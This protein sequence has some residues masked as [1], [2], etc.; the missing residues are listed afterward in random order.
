[1]GDLVKELRNVADDLERVVGLADKPF[2]DD[3]DLL[4]RAAA[5][6]DTLR[7]A[8]REI[9]DEPKGTWHGESYDKC[10]P[11]KEYYKSVIEWC[12]DRA[13]EALNVNPEFTKVVPNDTAARGVVVSKGIAERGQTTPSGA[14]SPETD[15]TTAQFGG[16]DAGEV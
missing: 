3:A 6:I 8:L 12:Q 10:V 13:A 15:T 1:V 9:R 4:R 11:S 14:E 7:A 16:Y 5:E 2:S